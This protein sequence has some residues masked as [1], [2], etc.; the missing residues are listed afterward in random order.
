MDTSDGG[1]REGLLD[2]NV[3]R[4]PR[5]WLGPR[6]ELIPVGRSADGPIDEGA[7][8]SADAFWGESSA[9]IQDALPA[10]PDAAHMRDRPMVLARASELVR[11]HAR[12]VSALAA[13]AVLAAVAVFG[14]G[15]HSSRHRTAGAA[16]GEVMSSPF[17]DA[18]PHVTSASR[19]LVLDRAL[20]HRATGRHRPRLGVHRSHHPRAEHP[21]AAAPQPVQYTSPPPPSS[22]GSETTAASE[23]TPN[24]VSSP[25]P[26]TDATPSTEST[27]PASS[28]SSQA[29]LGAN[30]ALA[31]GS[32]P[33]G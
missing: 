21:V 9:S 23:A 25:S 22:A 11:R 29:A 28:S 26:T 1:G 5:D 6:E 31:P 27:S 20:V 8:P 18:A 12:I 4:L 2:D 32:S 16:G 19:A 7:S 24:P 15:G 17:A 3:V 10:L 30:G 33:D 14:T 13:A